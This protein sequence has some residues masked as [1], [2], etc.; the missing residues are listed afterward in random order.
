MIRQ[1]ERFSALIVMFALIGAV[2]AAPMLTGEVRAIDAQQIYTPPSNSSPV[3]LRYFVP[4]GTRVK[5]GDVL[6]R[7]DPGDAAT[8]LRQLASQIEQAQAKAAKEV[9]ELRVKAVDAE[10][11]QVDADAATE[12]ARVDA[13][14]PR[15][16]ISRL[17]FDRYH[18]EL[19]RAERELVLK[20]YELA[21][22]RAAVDRRIADG[23][24]EVEKLAAEHDFNQVQVQ[25]AQVRAE[26]G[27]VLVH[28]FNSQSEAGGRYDEGSSSYPGQKIGEVVGAGPMAVRAYALEPDRAGLAPEQIVELVFDALPGRRV[29]GH[30]TAISGA[31]EPK[32]EWGE[33]RYFQIDIALPDQSQLQ[34][35]PGMSVRAAPI[36]VDTPVKPA[37]PVKAAA[38]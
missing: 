21:G 25:L 7:I 6:V 3:V 11:A 35:R 26:R 31:P 15:T 14:I 8:R 5:P 36:K 4:E 13:G 18:G 2:N 17:D 32:A 23:R 29:L 34:L 16:L 10:L 19:D 38:P 24:L 1:P 22:A 12:T 28:A 20:T 33:G 9:A 27:G 37:A 30:I